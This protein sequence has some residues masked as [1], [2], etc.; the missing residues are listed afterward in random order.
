MHIP[1]EGRGELPCLKYLARE[2]V[3]FS[4]GHATIT[5]DRAHGK[6]AEYLFY[7]YMGGGAQ[8]NEVK[9]PRGDQTQRF[10]YYFN[11]A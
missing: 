2:L 5:N 6:A 8:K 3:H 10:I 1:P 9:I 11:K 7:V 4:S